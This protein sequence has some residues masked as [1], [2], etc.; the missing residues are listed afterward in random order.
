MFKN[1]TYK[2]EIFFILS[3]F[4]ALLSLNNFLLNVCLGLVLLRLFLGGKGFLILF[5]PYLVITTTVSFSLVIIQEKDSNRVSIQYNTTKGILISEKDYKPGSVL[6]GSFDKGNDYLCSV[7][8]DKNILYDFQIPL[9]SHLL[10]YRQHI[11]DKLYIDSAGS[12]KII[13]ALVTGDRTYINDSTKDKLI[14]TG[15]IHLLAISG[16]HVG[17]VVLILYSILFF[18]P[19]KIRYIIISLFLFLFIPLTGFKITV[20]RASIFAITLMMTYFFDLGINLRKFVLFLVAVF[21]LI[22]PKFLTDVSFILSFAAVF[23]IIYL[24]QEYK[25]KYAGLLL[26]GIA[27]TSITLPV[28]LFIFGTFNYLSV[29]NTIIMLPF[30]YLAVFFGLISFVIPGIMIFPLTYV[31][32]LVM[33][34]VNSLYNLT[35]PAFILYKIDLWVLIFSSLFIFII[36]FTRYRWCVVFIYFITILPVSMEEGIYVPAQ[37]KSKYFVSINEKNDK[38]STH[39][40]EIF[41]MGNYNDFKYKFLPFLAKYKLKTFDKGYINIFGGENLYLNIDMVSSDYDN[42]CVNYTP[43]RP[44]NHFSTMLGTDNSDNGCNIIFVIRSNTIA[45]YDVKG[46]NKYIIYKNNVKATNIYEIKETGPLH[47]Y[48]DTVNF[49]ERGK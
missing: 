34:M 44:L 45:K 19:A 3:V 40:R 23:G 24:M 27:A 14:I 15:V 17:I 20:V 28:T 31:E 32:N 22:S 48:K 38:E 41:F 42:I 21:L 13:Q 49:L 26:V 35:Y 2:V 1:C 11:S 29:L 37:T 7:I 47:I 12:I 39:K 16:L 33:W 10:Y 5:L 8:S 9:I 30:V 36:I 18:L 43:A 46:D 4:T 25:N 6:I